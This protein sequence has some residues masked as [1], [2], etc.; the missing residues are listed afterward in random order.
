MTKEGEEVT[1]GTEIEAGAMAETTDRKWKV[2]EVEGRELVEALVGEEKGE[3]LGTAMKG[4]VGKEQ[5]EEEEEEE[6]E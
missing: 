1:I 4:E 2:E 3:E 6:E 5:M